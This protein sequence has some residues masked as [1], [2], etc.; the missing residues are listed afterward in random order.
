MVNCDDV[1]NGQG[2]V[3]DYYRVP[4]GFPELPVPDDNPLTEAKVLLG[5][6]LFFERSLSKDSSLSCATCHNPTMGFARAGEKIASGF[7]GEE[8]FRNILP[9]FNVAYYPNL[10]W[11]GS[12]NSIE[13][14]AHHVLSLPNEFNND[15]L[16]IQERLSSHPDY[17]DMF[18]SAF[19]ETAMPDAHNIS[20]AIAAY[21]RTILSGNSPYDRYLNGVSSALDESQKRGMELFFS[22]RLACA[23]CHSGIFFTDMGFHNTATTTHYFDRGRFYVT[24]DP[25]DR[26]KFKTPTLRNVE[27][28]YPYM[29]N[30]EL[31]T[32][33]DVM[34]HYSRGGYLF[35]HKDTLL[36][37]LYLNDIEK[38]D[39]INFLKSLTDT[40]FKNGIFP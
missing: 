1:S 21:I 37:P 7:E 40:D 22:D 26:G 6:K 8:I 10:T 28:T 4:D 3:K 2:E 23:K 18:R 19:G 12:A 5:K 17:P 33:E 39:V 13:I 29:H 20:Y 34:N 9:M 30:G 35:I 27:L 36:K 11:D 24:N 16:V 31:E 15:T 38:Q 25:W 14:I 32:L